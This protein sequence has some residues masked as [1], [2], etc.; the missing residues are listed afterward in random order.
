MP[1]PAKLAA[2]RPRGT[3]TDELI[4]DVSSKL[5][6]ERGYDR[7]TLDDVAAELSVTKPSLYYYFR[8]KEEILLACIAAAYAR[9]RERLA[10]ADDPA[11]SGRR[12]V[13]LMMRIYMEVISDDTGV[14]IVLADERVMAEAGQKLYREMRR[15]LNAALERRIAHGVSDGSLRTRDVSTTAAAIFGMFNW[16]S[17][18]SPNR[19]A[20]GPEAISDHFLE[21]LFD[22]L[23]P[24]AEGR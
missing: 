1:K 14:S 8:S 20:A 10:A 19:R 21:L 12:R 7:T 16:V 15:E 11:Y 4:L 9:M 6:R 13:E 2:R 22:G 18:W 5:F 17:H 3:L 24:K 23:A